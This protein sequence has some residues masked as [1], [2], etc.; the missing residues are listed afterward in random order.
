VLAVLAVM[1]GLAHIAG[2][3]KSGYATA[4]ALRLQWRHGPTVVRAGGMPPRLLKM[5]TK[6]SVVSFTNVRPPL[7]KAGLAAGVALLVMA[8]A[9]PATAAPAPAGSVQK[10]MEAVAGVPGVVGAVGGAYVDGK[11]IGLGSA[12]TRLLGGKGGTIPANARFRIGSQTKQMVGTVVLQ[13][14]QEGKLGLNDKLGDVLPV[15][16]KKDLVQDADDI[17]VAE[18]IRHTSGIP[19]WYAAAPNPDGSEGALSFDPF[20]FTTYYRPLDLVKTSRSRPRTGEPGERYSYSNTNYTLLGLIIEKVTGHDL[21]T[22]LHRHLFGPLGMTKTYLAM[23]P[24]EG[25]KGPHGHGYYPD[26]GGTP[27]DVDRFNASYGTGAG[28]VISTAHD[29][30]AFYRAFSQGKLLPP[31]LQRVLTGPLPG[32]PPQ[33]NG[34]GFC[35][36]KLDGYIWG[37]TTAGYLAMTFYSADGREQLAMSA[38]LSVKDI[39]GAG[40]AMFNAVNTVFCPSSSA[41]A[42]R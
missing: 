14:V 38:T 21:A 5:I 1:P 7:R 13:L 36:G 9:E 24:P 28:G 30:S 11:P 4:T 27:R 33:G 16:V 26:A 10:A 18:M 35:D 2:V 42:A 22:A 34:P 40:Q 32:D 23:K 39:S 15:V 6:R 17:T 20:D 25:I 3:S 37:G 8:G 19:D 41:A 29:V 31:E 12:G